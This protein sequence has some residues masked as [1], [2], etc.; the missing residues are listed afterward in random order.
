MLRQNI[1]QHENIISRSYA[2]VVVRWQRILP[3]RSRRRPDGPD[4]LELHCPPVHGRIPHT[5]QSTRCEFITRYAVGPAQ[6]GFSYGAWL[7]FEPCHLQNMPAL[8]ALKKMNPCPS[9]VKTFSRGSKVG[10]GFILVC[11]VPCKVRHQ[12]I[13]VRGRLMFVRGEPAKLLRQ[14]PRFCPCAAHCLAFHPSVRA[15]G[16]VFFRAGTRDAFH[17]PDASGRGASKN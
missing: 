7:I 9:V 5:K 2:S 12:S 1:F 15:N 8:R 11:R 6:R 4:S 10:H 3:G 17:K 14:F 13:L 16:N